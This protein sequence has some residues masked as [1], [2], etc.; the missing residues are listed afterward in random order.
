MPI[1][2]LSRMLRT[3]IRSGAID[4]LHR[5]V[6]LNGFQYGSLGE[7]A[8]ASGISSLSPRTG[9]T[10]FPVKQALNWRGQ[11]AVAPQISKYGAVQSSSDRGQ[12]F[13]FEWAPSGN[14][15]D[16]IGSLPQNDVT[17]AIVQTD[18]PTT[19]DH[20]LAVDS[21]FQ[22]A[23]A[24]GAGL[25]QFVSVGASISLQTW[26]FS[27]WVATI[28]PT[29]TA[30]KSIY[31]AIGNNT[32]TDVSSTTATYTGA[33][34]WQRVSFT[35]TFLV[36]TTSTSILVRVGPISA[37][38][39]GMLIAAAQL[40]Q[41][42]SP[43]VYERT[44]YTVAGVRNKLLGS[45]FPTRRSDGAPLTV[46]PAASG[47]NWMVIPAVGQKYAV[48]KYAG[49]GPEIR[50]IVPTPG[51]MEFGCGIAGPTW[52]D[53]QL[54]FAPELAQAA[55]RG[56]RIRV[57][58]ASALNRGVIQS[59]A[60]NPNGNTMI[61]SVWLRAPAAATGYVVPA[62]GVY[63]NLSTT[64]AG[65][66]TA[67]SSVLIPA[68][69]LTQAWR[70]YW[71]T[72]WPGTGTPDACQFQVLIRGDGGTTIVGEAVEVWG[73]QLEVQTGQV[74]Q[75][76]RDYTATTGSAAGNT[77]NALQ[78]SS[79][80]A[81]SPWAVGSNTTVDADI[82]DEPYEHYRAWSPSFGAGPN[83]I[84]INPG[85]ASPPVPWS[86]QAITARKD[87]VQGS[88]ASIGAYGTEKLGVIGDLTW[89]GA[90]LTGWTITGAGISE[91]TGANAWADDEEA[92]G[93]VS[94][95]TTALA[96]SQSAPT[97]YINNTSVIA[98]G[99]DWYT[100]RMR[101]ARQDQTPQMRMAVKRSSDNLF[102]DQDHV[103]FVSGSLDWLTPHV[104]QCGVNSPDFGVAIWH[105]YLPTA[106]NYTFYFGG[107]TSSALTTKVLHFDSIRIWSGGGALY[108]SLDRTETEGA[109]QCLF[110]GFNVLFRG[111]ID[112]SI[113]ADDNR[114]SVRCRDYPHGTL[115]QI[116]TWTTQPNCQVKFRGTECG[117]LSTTSITVADGSPTTTHTV[118][119]TVNLQAGRYI[120][121]STG[122]TYTRILAIL[123][124]TQFTT[125]TPQ[126]YANLQA[127]SYADCKKTYPDCSLRQRTHRYSGCR[128]TQA[129]QAMGGTPLYRMGIVAAPGRGR[130]RWSTSGL[131][132][133]SA[134]ELLGALSIDAQA[135]LADKKIFDDTSVPLVYGRKSIKAIPVETHATKFGTDNTEWLTT[136][137]V[138]GMGE[139][140]D[141][142][143]FFTPDGPI[144]H[145]PA[146]G[147]AVYWHP[148][149]QGEDAWWT[150]A[151]Q[152]GVGTPVYTS[153]P[154]LVQ[155]IDNQKRD[156]R[157][158]TDNSYNRMAYAVVQIKKGNALVDLNDPT[159][160]IDL[161]CD[162]KARLVQ[163]YDALGAPVGSPA[164]S[165]NPIWI[166]VDAL[167]NGIFG[168]AIPMGVIDWQQMVVSAAVCDEAIVSAVAVAQIR[169]TT[170]GVSDSIWGVTSIDGF[171]PEMPC[172]VNGVANKVLF[173]D[174]INLRLFFET[175]FTAVTGWVIQGLPA[176]YTCDL[177]ISTKEDLTTVLDMVMG[178]CRGFLAFDGG[179]L[180][181]C[182]ETAA[183]DASVVP[184]NIQTP[185]SSTTLL[186]VIPN[187]IHYDQRRGSGTNYN[188]LE[189]TYE[190][191][192]L[193]AGS[194]RVLKFFDADRGGLDFPRVLKF[195]AAGCDTAEQAIR[196]F[197][198]RFAKACSAA[199]G[200]DT[201]QDVR[202]LTVE[203]G[204][205]LMAAQVGDFIVL[206]R[207]G[208]TTSQRARIRSLTIAPNL[209]VE[210]Q[211][212]PEARAIRPEGFSAPFDPY[213][214][215]PLIGAAMGN[216]LPL[217]VITLSVEQFSG[218]QVRATISVTGYSAGPGTS[219]GTHLEKFVK[220][221]LH[222]SLLSG[223]TPTTGTFMA[224][225]TLV[226]VIDPAVSEFV[227]HVPI[228]RMET[229][230]YLKAVG[231]VGGIDGA[232]VY[233]AE[234]PITTYYTDR[235]V[236]DPTQH[237]RSHFH[238]M[239]YGG[240]F[241]PTDA[242][243]SDGDLPA[244]PSDLST[245]VFPNA[246]GVGAASVETPV[247]PSIRDEHLPGG[248]ITYQTVKLEDGNVFGAGTAASFSTIAK[249]TDANDATYFMHTSR[250]VGV[251]DAM[252]V[253]EV[254]LSGFGSSGAN[255]VGRPYFRFRRPT[256]S[257]SNLGKIALYYILDITVGGGVGNGWNLIGEY[258][259]SPDNLAN[260]VFGEELTGV[261]Y[262]KFGL[263]VRF[264]ASKFTN[265]TRD[266]LHQ[267]L[268]CGFQQK[269]AATYTGSVSGFIG[270]MYG[271]GTNYGN[272]RHAFPAKIPVPDQ[273]VF[274]AQTLNTVRFELKKHVSSDTLDSNV[275]EVRLVDMA[276]PENNWVLDQVPSSE[277]GNAWT[278]F[279]Q[280]FI[281]ATP[282]KGAD[283]QIEIRTKNTKAID[284]R[285]V[286][287]YRGDTICAW[288]TS[289][290]EQSAGWYGELSGGEPTGFTKGSWGNTR[291]KSQVQ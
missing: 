217:G 188:A 1:R 122:S 126:T 29:D 171:T 130:F 106:T 204:I 70:R 203:S 238:N 104:K 193:L 44:S 192:Q 7:V 223:F 36:G 72:W 172:T 166:G 60:V 19:C 69:M 34:K 6:A 40:E 181:I 124:G 190:C 89:A 96:A 210:A 286:G 11:S 100:V 47:T 146:E 152:F 147:I 127:I 231:V 289:P 235:P 240:G 254:Q 164:W 261:D 103:R 187:S 75:L 50:A 67:N 206:A 227:W 30:N 230:V 56:D 108:A 253:A 213:T 252:T 276:N 95:V 234:V 154:A 48:G 205:S 197:L 64:T 35:K 155:K 49:R 175:P 179:K 236:T 82:A 76:P 224:G 278:A 150:L 107:F 211:T 195:E 182:I 232:V 290:E 144:V 37:A 114:I 143:Q 269:A 266:S 245:L 173:V 281:P 244:Y 21:Y 220:F 282:I 16:I 42:A 185:T 94:G 273:M 180:G 280:K 285:R 58:T 118:T 263:G 200:L 87:N 4:V 169:S 66:A 86:F 132:R 121:S 101:V 207:T 229:Q 242:W 264:F 221:E 5:V 162:L 78:Q 184:W 43:T 92:S 137:Y 32:S 73:C 99:Q 120:L 212:A 113:D 85:G 201:T 151:D 262:S 216:P 288:S 170:G 291:K 202:G 196:A 274:N 183:A 17:Y 33:G 51:T 128:A 131:V 251:S 228:L 15:E 26:T 129:L 283:L 174:P 84:R 90:V 267:L 219:A 277:I 22:T 243:L 133:A 255:K 46:Y 81:T 258:V 271:D 80:I 10:D 110:Q 265:I 140:A 272:L 239:V 198:P 59:I 119:T 268:R 25:A 105:I 275:F 163:V 260:E 28:D 287:V 9:R 62:Q 142:R 135:S 98:L 222:A 116:P 12:E 115:Q 71:W 208:R 88:L 74:S 55:V 97:T 41:A 53:G 257:A 139:L 77:I 237:E 249:I 91:A 248:S 246:S 63:L 38:S 148:G 177:S 241:R 256:Q 145:S 259:A 270:T 186:G 136:F 57:T 215:A 159:K 218:G 226:A 123:N 156:F 52:P 2:R 153:G 102:L 178:S 168:P 65:A 83:L 93:A 134:A 167:L 191:G 189:L 79:A 117:Y 111:V 138:M 141:V 39:V 165:R 125:D 20:G 8:G 23:N 199:G 149:R 225:G 284:V 27:V 14:T 109:T 157:T 13:T 61:G 3:A 31:L 68:S 18:C 233:S 214:D 279:I 250:Y 54:V 45:H 112:D 160:I 176:R 24:G 158:N 194:N 161:W 209:T 247:S